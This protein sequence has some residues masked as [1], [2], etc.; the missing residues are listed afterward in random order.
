M[1]KKHTH[2]I[3]MQPS[4]SS[5]VE[6]SHQKAPV[7]REHQQGPREKEVDGNK[8]GWRELGKDS[9]LNENQNNKKQTR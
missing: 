1:P 8:N 4:W 2:V 5:A 7:M 3:P 6:Y 9:V